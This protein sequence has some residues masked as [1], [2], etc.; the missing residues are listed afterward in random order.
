MRSQTTAINYESS[1][2]RKTKRPSFL[3]RLVQRRFANFSCGKLTINFP[4]GER[5]MQ[6]GVTEGPEATMTVRRWRGI[7]RL[8]SDGDIGL[9]ATYIDG[10]WTTDDLRAVLEYGMANEAALASSA[11]GAKILHGLNLLRHALRRNSRKG[12]RRNIAAHYD[13]GND[14]YRQWL[15]EG[16]QYS[17]AIFTSPDDSLA[18][19][20][21]RKLDHIE[22]MLDLK[23][24]EKILE[25]GC[26][27]GAVAERLITRHQCDVTGITLSREQAAFARDRLTSGRAAGKAQIELLDYRD[28]DQTYDR[29]VSIEMLEAVG[30]KY[31]PVYFEKLAQSLKQGGIAVI[32]VITIADS[33]F[34]EYRRKPDFI[35]KYIF[36][37][38]ML[39]TKTALHQQAQQA[40]LEIVE[41]EGFG[42]SYQRTLEAW[43]EAFHDNWGRIEPLGFDDRFRRMWHYYLCYC[44]T[45]FNHGTIDVGLYKLVKSPA[46]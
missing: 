30:E 5:L 6:T 18:T 21:E 24:H 15:D 38:G 39:P 19:A 29:I 10:D 16:M 22:A 42:K 43:R 23:G 33:Y 34:E 37:G 46:A 41:Q 31:W 1:S 40:N 3:L 8:F 9:A 4:N 11:G 25:I 44:E 13:L 12:S 35:Q 27:W 14:F 45:G 2:N 17:S 26:G 36:P 7:F 28:V 20:Q 32:Q